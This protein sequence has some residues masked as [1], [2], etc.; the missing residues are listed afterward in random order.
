MRVLVVNDRQAEL[1]AIVRTVRRAGHRV[2]QS[3]D[4]T[5][6]LASAALDPANVIIVGWPLPSDADVVTLLSGGGSDQ[7]YVIVVLDSANAGRNIKAL[8]AAG[9]DD[10]L[11]RPVINEELLA[12][13][14]ASRRMHR[15]ATVDALDWSSGTDL[16]RLRAWRSMG[17]IVAARLALMIRRPVEAVQGW[18]SDFAGP[19]RGA[20]IALSL[21]SVQAEA[22]IS[23]TVNRQA[24]SW[25][26]EVL[27]H[28]RNAD[29]SAIADM[30]REMAN[31]AG[32]GVARAAVLENVTLTLGMPVTDVIP[33]QPRTKTVQAYEA[34]VDGGKV[35]IGILGKVIRRESVRLPARKL[36]EGMV[37][38]SDLRKPDGVLLVAAGTRLTWTTAE[39]VT[40]TVGGSFVVEVARSA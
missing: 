33:A 9:A 29:S 38:V 36:R 27:L 37:M 19:L 18:P 2:E 14:E 11:L 5:S 3:A 24:Q 7:T 20:T 17:A 34:L 1:Q 21:V 40:Q 10:F 35:R 4:A 8:L 25:L 32:G 15:W 6:A 16:G 30:L 13:V 26:A 23:I 39:Q 28:N 31:T 12:R 22:H